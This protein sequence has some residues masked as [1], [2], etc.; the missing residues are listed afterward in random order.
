MGRALGGFVM[1]AVMA[2][3]VFTLNLFF[4]AAAAFLRALPWLVPL[5]WRTLRSLLVLSS[6]QYHQIL[7]RA[8]PFFEKHWGLRIL[9]R[10]WRRLSTIVLSVLLGLLSL[11]I[12]RL[13]VNLFVLLALLPFP[14]WLVIFFALYGLLVDLVWAETPE[15]QNFQMGVKL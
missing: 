8:A 13:P 15:G 10:K 5:A 9:D 12:T 3:T 4:T 2:L 1:Q 6:R 7:T 11:L 14:L